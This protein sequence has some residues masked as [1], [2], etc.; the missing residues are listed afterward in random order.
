VRLSCLEGRFS[1]STAYL[2][3]LDRVV[4]D[5]P[6]PKSCAWSDIRHG[7]FP[8]RRTCSCSGR[9]SQGAGCRNTGGSLSDDLRSG[10]RDR[11]PPVKRSRTDGA[12]RR[13]YRFRVVRRSPRRRLSLAL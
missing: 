6:A 12:Y 4:A 8:R 2:D 7:L 5:H 13:S 9:S 3:R 1:Q 11:Y 10:P